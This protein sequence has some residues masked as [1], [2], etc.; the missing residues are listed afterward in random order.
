MK[1]DFHI[2]TKFSWDAFS[3]PQEVVDSAIENGI[4]CICITDHGEIKG[5]IE[6]MKYGFDKNILVIPGIEILSQSGDI[7]GINV[8]KIIPNYLS[9]QRTIK[10]IHKQGG[11]AIFP[12]PFWL[13]GNSNGKKKNLLMA[14]AIEVFNADVF[15]FANKRALK[16]SKRNGLP[17]TAG[18]DAHKA[19]F[20]GRG[21]LEIP[22]KNISEKEVIEEV[23]KKSG[24]IKGEMLNFWEKIGNSL[25]VD[26]AKVI[27]Q[28][29]ELKSKKRKI[30]MDWN[31][32]R[33]FFFQNSSF[34]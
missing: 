7:L 3:S 20:I 25:K 4:D 12:H 29:Y 28:Y 19:K 22:K 23:K 10:E 15:S 26:P 24:K 1:I 32:R 13:F 27:S 11:M 17:F 6:A 31:C 14:D 21:Y 30:E 5:A 33:K 9:A 34:T 8:K 18:S 16:F 2:H